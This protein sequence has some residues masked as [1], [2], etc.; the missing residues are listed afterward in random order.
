MPVCARGCVID[1]GQTCIH[2]YVCLRACMRVQQH[3][4]GVVG[5]MASALST[6]VGCTGNLPQGRGVSLVPRCAVRAQ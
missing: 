4:T 1:S 5:G 6:V 3:D 2:V